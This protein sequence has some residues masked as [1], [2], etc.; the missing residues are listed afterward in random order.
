MF[1]VILVDDEQ[2]ALNGL[3]NIIQW[4]DY[5]FKVKKLCS[6]AEDALTA[7]RTHRPDA[8]FTDI[9]MP[10][11][12]GDEFI[13]MIRSEGI[14]TEFVIVSA[15]RDFNVA[16][17]AISQGVLYYLT[18]PLDKNEVVNVIST[19]KKK[20]NEKNNIFFDEQGLLRIPSGNALNDRNILNYL[21]QCA[22]YPNCFLVL[23]HHVPL[24]RHY[25]SK[26]INITHL[27]FPNDVKASL[28][29]ISLN[30]YHVLDT[31]SYGI[32]RKHGNFSQLLDMKKEAELS[33][34]FMIRYSDNPTVSALQA[35]LAARYNQ[36]IKM[37]EIAEQFYLSESYLFEL[38]KK[39]TN[40]TIIQFITGLRIKKAC[41]LLKVSDLPI[42]VISEKVGY[43]DLSYFGRLFRRQ[44]KCSPACYRKNY[45]ANS[46]RLE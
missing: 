14:E 17:K 40:T 33:A 37:R 7:I 32:S 28:V 27:L 30:M 38:F 41:T 16:Q 43:E 36:K 4:E 22:V 10:G 26:E 5:G 31:V 8:I 19:L 34:E 18:K 42:S 11:M 1:S 23:D 25:K 12:N 13:N 21:E 9:R 35:Y 20:L 29:S 24:Q 15:Y 46:P 39:H 44:M 3:K 45:L 6:S 2:W